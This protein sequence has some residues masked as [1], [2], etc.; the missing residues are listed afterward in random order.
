MKPNK[1]FVLLLSFLGAALLTWL[2]TYW[3]VMLILNE[4]IPP[5]QGD[6]QLWIEALGRTQ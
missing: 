2:V 1:G 3:I 5:T 6:C 4:P